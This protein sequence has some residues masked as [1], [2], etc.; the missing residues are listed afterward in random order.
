MQT[1]NRDCE[2]KLRGLPQKICKLSGSQFDML[3]P[4]ERRVAAGEDARARSH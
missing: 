4:I 1:K 2:E 3:Q